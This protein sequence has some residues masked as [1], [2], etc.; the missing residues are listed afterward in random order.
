MALIL[1]AHGAG[2]VELALI[3]GAH[4]TG[5]VYSRRRRWRGS[6]PR[7][8][9]SIELTSSI[10]DLPLSRTSSVSERPYQRGNGIAI[11]FKNFQGQ[12]LLQVFERCHCCNHILQRKGAAGKGASCGSRCVGVGDGMSWNAWPRIALPM[13]FWSWSICEIWV[14]CV[15]D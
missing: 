1:G 10:R 8:N 9:S 14:P 11:H 5:S 3:L 4:G 2:S 12:S 13:D 15:S 7:A 6:V